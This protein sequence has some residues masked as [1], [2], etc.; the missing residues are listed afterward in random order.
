MGK[1]DKIADFSGR[2]GQTFAG[3]VK[4][5]LL[6]RRPTVVRDAQPGDELVVLGNGP[7]L[8]ETV[9]NHRDFLTSRKKLAVNFAGNTPLF[10]DLKPDYYVLADPHFFGHTDKNVDTLW[11]NLSAVDW[12][13]TL[14]VPASVKSDRLDAVSRHPHIRLSRYNTT[15]VEGFR[16]FR[17]W[18]YR[19]GAGMPRPR[20]VL[21]PSIMLAL[22]A[23]FRTVY[24]A[25]ADHSWMKTL[26]VDE[27]NRVVSVQPHFYKDNDKEKARVSSEYSNYK[28][29]QIVYSFYV[30]F[31]SYHEI[32]DYADSQGV[33]IWNITPGSFIDA[34][35][36]RKI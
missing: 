18:A 11:S 4:I 27:E 35:S 26:S 2:L 9:G 32:R 29:H 25:G 15:P 8:N 20:N 17:H 19:S 36:R 30:A 28:L 24:V 34:F 23:G 22:G 1:L 6:S 21:I 3:M 31:K 12:Q 13:M 7:S 10:T 33:T 5:L 16:W 14:F